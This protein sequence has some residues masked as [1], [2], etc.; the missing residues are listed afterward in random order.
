MR[1]DLFLF[2]NGYVKSR[3]KAKELIEKSAVKVDGKIITKP[4]FDV[5]SASIEID[6]SSMP[7]VGR[8][9]FKLEAA[10]D[11]FCIDVSGLRCIDV[12]ASTGGFTDCL[13]QRGAEH[14]L[15]VDCGHGQLDSELACDER[16]SQLEGFNARNLSP[17]E[18]EE[19][20]DL[21]VMDVSFISQTLIH[22]PLSSVL[23]K[24]ATF[25]TLIKPQFEAGRKSL[26]NK[27]IVKS[28]SDRKSALKKVFESAD[29]TGFVLKGY[30]E[31]PIK[32]GDGNTEY[33]AVFIY[34]GKEHLS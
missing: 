17:A 27:G 13:L 23:K 9:G 29:A 25:I 30:I 22:T 12:G 33:L 21:A 11:H 26:S 7:F 5:D 1:L 31:S 16:V 28:E 10:L 15:A 18:T 20:F 6:D 14:V 2:E 8:G 3:S 32:G 4:S 19:L 24:G 34:N